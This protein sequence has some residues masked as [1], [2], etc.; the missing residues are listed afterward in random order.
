[1]FTSL[2]ICRR[3]SWQQHASSFVWQQLIDTTKEEAK[4]RLRMGEIFAKELT[5][6]IAQRC[7]DLARISKRVSLH[8]HLETRSP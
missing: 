4:E 7:D 6:S 1:M 2:N 5:A 3:E 8:L